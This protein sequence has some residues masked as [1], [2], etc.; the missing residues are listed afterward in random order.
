V[1][2]EILL[3]AWHLISKMSDQSGGVKIEGV[4]VPSWAVQPPKTT[5]VNI[6]KDGKCIK[7][8]FV[9]NRKHVVFGRNETFANIRLD[10]ESCSRTHAMIIYHKD[11]K[12]LFIYDFN[13]SHG[14]HVDGHRI[15][16]SQF[17]MLPENA[18]FSFGASTRTYKIFLPSKNA[19]IQNTVKIE[20]ETESKENK[21]PST[22]DEIEELAVMN[23]AT[24]ERIP[25]EVKDQKFHPPLKKAKLN[26]IEFNPKTEVFK[27]NIANLRKGRF[28]SLASTFAV[29]NNQQVSSADRSEKPLHSARNLAHQPNNQFIGTNFSLFSQLG[30][31]LPNLAPSLDNSDEYQNNDSAYQ[32][33]DLIAT[34][35]YAKEHWPEQLQQNY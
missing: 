23:T 25:I 19:K 12:K 8:I 1:E 5:H 18:D 16:P 30:I 32:E 31:K 14:T 22:I 11:A 29:T 6:Y 27:F 3:Q 4:E 10:H 21:L 9:D 15:E 28:K 20:E 34:K 33:E 7:K 35:K 24:N 26:S 2:V 17:F 13:S